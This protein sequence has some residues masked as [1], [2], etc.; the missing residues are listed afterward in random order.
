MPGKA[1][2]LALENDPDLEFE[3]YLGEKLSRTVTEVR[4]MDNA[5]FVMWTRYYARKAQRRELEQRMAG[6]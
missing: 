2:Y 5:E 1:A 3:H 6:G 4:S